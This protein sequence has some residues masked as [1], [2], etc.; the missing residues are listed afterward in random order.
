MSLKI[1]NAFTALTIDLLFIS[2]SMF[3]YSIWKQFIF[4]LPFD[5]G[6]VEASMRT[7]LF[8]R[9]YEDIIDPC[10]IYSLL[11][12]AYRC[13]VLQTYLLF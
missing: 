4:F 6:Y 13:K 8:L 9:D 10:D 11:G 1:Y 3:R 7:C 12:M 5:L 2:D